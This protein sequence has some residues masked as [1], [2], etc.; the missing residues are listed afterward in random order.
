MPFSFSTPSLNP[1]ARPFNRRYWNRH[2][3]AL[4][5]DRLVVGSLTAAC[6]NACA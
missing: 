4:D 1:V 6:S 5:Q 2:E 3:H